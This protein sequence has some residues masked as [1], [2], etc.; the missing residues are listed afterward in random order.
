VGAGVRVTVSLAEDRVRPRPRGT[1][2]EHPVR[3]TVADNGPGIPPETVTRIFDPFFT[4]K[5]KGSGLGLAVVHRAVEAHQGATFVERAPEGGAQFV[6][7]LPGAPE[8][9]PASVG[10]SA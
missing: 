9:A 4:T 2:I 7:F 10:A 5:P 8:S 3:L 6:I 1:D